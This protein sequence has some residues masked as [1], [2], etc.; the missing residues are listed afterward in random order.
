MNSGRI[1]TASDQGAHLLRLEGD[2]RLIMCTALDEHLE[3]I[4][5]DPEFASVW[6][7]VT[8]A[9]GLDSTTLGMLAKLAIRTKERFGFKPAMFS[10]NPGINRLLKS[11]GFSKLYEL[12]SGESVTND[13]T[14]ELPQV[15]AS[16]DVV[17]QKVIDA[18]KTLMSLT[19]ENRK[20]FKDLV[21]TLETG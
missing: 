21:Q 16:E 3:K 5:S 8:G 9:T 15:D 6:V 14:A 1:S 20:A 19:E 17:R 10:D 18:H 13:D 2:V 7:D 12:R 4:F 11:M